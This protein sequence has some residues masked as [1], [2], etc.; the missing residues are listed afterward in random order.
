MRD[1]HFTA[2][3]MQALSKRDGLDVWLVRD[4]SF[5]VGAQLSKLVS[6]LLSSS[7]AER[8][9]ID[10]RWD[11]PKGCTATFLDGKSFKLA[12]TRST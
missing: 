12:A 8:T 10:P 7:L 2:G 4:V 5:S 11:A 9:G 3:S 6:G 1:F